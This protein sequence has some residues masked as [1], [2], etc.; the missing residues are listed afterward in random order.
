MGGAIQR[1]SWLNLEYS[2]LWF[3]A[4]DGGGRKP[5]LPCLIQACGAARCNPFV[6]RM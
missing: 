6:T 3:K 1:N 2:L 5:V 4:C